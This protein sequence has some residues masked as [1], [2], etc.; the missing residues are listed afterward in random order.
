ME[1]QEV[2]VVIDRE[3]RVQ[4]H[5]QGVQGTACLDLTADLEKALGTV[6]SREMTPEAQAQVHVE[7]HHQV[8]GS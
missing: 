2:E 5:V 3:G 8:K 1:M 6:E 4:I 7:A